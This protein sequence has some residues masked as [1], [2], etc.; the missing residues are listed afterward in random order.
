MTHGMPVSCAIITLLKLMLR[1]GFIRV[2]MENFK[3]VIIV[4][5]S[6]LHYL[7]ELLEDKLY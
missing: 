6:N 2:E 1:N 3:R 7:N 4:G 5:N